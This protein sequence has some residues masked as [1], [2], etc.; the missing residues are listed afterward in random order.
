MGAVVGGGCLLS[1]T[2]SITETLVILRKTLDRMV[3]QHKW[4]E[5]KRISNRGFKMVHRYGNIVLH[6]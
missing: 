5:T 3:W 6:S 1:N 2:V 4:W